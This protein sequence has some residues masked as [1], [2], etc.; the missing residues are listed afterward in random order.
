MAATACP[1]CRRPIGLGAYFSRLWFTHIPCPS[2][3][4]R[5]KVEGLT[6]YYLVTAIPAVLFGL[7]VKAIRLEHGTLGLCVLL[8]AGLL[9]WMTLTPDDA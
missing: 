3:G 9:T 2:C 6:L 1:S 8:V 7:K 4:K 5:L